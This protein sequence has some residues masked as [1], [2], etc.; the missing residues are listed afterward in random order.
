MLTL[1]YP[2][3]I[4]LGALHGLVAVKA[5]ASIADCQMRMAHNPDTIFINCRFPEGSAAAEIYPTGIIVDLNPSWD[6]RNWEYVRG[7][8]FGANSDVELAA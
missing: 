2:L 3:T 7:V 1:P 5:G 6:R 4:C 8:K